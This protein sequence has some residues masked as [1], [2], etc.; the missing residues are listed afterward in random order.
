MANGV[1][2]HLLN[3]ITLANARN[4]TGGG[5]WTD[6]LPY[7]EARGQMTAAHARSR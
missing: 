5:G 4:A 7:P 1:N 3:V 2:S 6:R